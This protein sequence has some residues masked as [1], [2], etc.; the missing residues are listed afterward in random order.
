MGRRWRDHL[1][2]WQER[3]LAEPVRRGPA[4]PVQQIRPVRAARPAD[5]CPTTGHTATARPADTRSAAA[6]VTGATV[7]LVTPAYRVA[8]GL[9]RRAPGPVTGRAA[10]RLGRVA[11]LT[12]PVLAA[13]FANSPTARQGDNGGRTA[14]WERVDPSRAGSA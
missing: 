10:R 2:W 8:A 6:S 9:A 14:M 11:Y 12:A 1:D 4:L 7:D 13:V 5:T 3:V